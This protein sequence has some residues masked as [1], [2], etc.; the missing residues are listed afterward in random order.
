MSKNLNDM[1]KELKSLRESTMADFKEV[2]TA[3]FDSAKK[4]RVGKS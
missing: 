3:D 2:E 1:K 4:R